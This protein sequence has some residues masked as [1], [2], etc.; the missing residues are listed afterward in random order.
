MCYY[1]L[2][3]ISLNLILKIYSGVVFNEC[4]NILILKVS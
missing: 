2:G 1:K 4:G 3:N